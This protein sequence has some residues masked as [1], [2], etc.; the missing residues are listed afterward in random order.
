LLNA[1]QVP[2]T[3]FGTAGKKPLDGILV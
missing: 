1:L 3:T 2:V